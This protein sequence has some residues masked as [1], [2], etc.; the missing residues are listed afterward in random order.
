MFLILMRLRE[1]LKTANQKS[2]L[3]GNNLFIGRIQ[4]RELGWLTIGCR[5]FVSQAEEYCTTR[6]SRHCSFCFYR[7]RPLNTA[8]SLRIFFDDESF[9]EIWISDKKYSYHWQKTDGKI[10]R[11]DN[12]PHKKHKHIKTFPKHFHD[13]SEGNVKES[14]TDDNPEIAVKDFLKFVREN[15]K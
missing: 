14:G 12:A 4:K 3:R 10:Y 6:I 11:H 1:K 13:G 2:I 8:K 9:L 5:N 7:Q 15:I